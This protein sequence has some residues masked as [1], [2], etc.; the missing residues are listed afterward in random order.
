MGQGTLWRDKIVFEAIATAIAHES[1]TAIDRLL[2]YLNEKRLLNSSSN[3]SVITAIRSLNLL[4]SLLL[5]FKTHIKGIFMTKKLQS[6]GNK[7]EKNKT[8][9]RTNQ[10]VVSIKLHFINLTLE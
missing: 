5:Q 2:F 6:P 8:K 9:I 1:Q 10:H 4:I 3:N 7:F